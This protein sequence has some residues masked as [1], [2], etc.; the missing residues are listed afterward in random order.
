[1]V[2]R[3]NSYLYSFR[4]FDRGF[5]WEDADLVTGSGTCLSPFLYSASDGTV[6]LAWCSNADGTYELYHTRSSDNGRTWEQPYRKIETPEDYSQSVSVVE[7]DPGTIQIYFDNSARVVSTDNGDNFDPIENFSSDD[8]FNSR[9]FKDSGGRLWLI[10]WS[11]SKVKCRYSDN[12][13]DSWSGTQEIGEA[14]GGPDDNPIMFEAQ[15]GTL[16][17][18]WHDMNLQEDLFYATSADNGAAWTSRKLITCSP[19]S[20]R[21]SSPSIY[22]VDNI[23]YIIYGNDDSGNFDLYLAAWPDF[24]GDG[25]LA[26]IDNCPGVYNPGQENDDGDDFGNACDNCS[27]VYNPSQEDLDSD[28]VGDS[29]DAL[30]IDFTGSPRNGTVPLEVSFS[31][32]SYTIDVITDWF[33]DFG[34]EQTSDLQNPVHTYTDSGSYDVTL[35]I[36]NGPEYDTLV[37]PDYIATGPP[38]NVDFSIDVTSGPINLV[39]NFTPSSDVALDSAFWEYGDGE[40]G[41]DTFHTYTTIDTFD[42]RYIFFIGNYEDTVLKE[43]AIITTPP[44]IN[45]MAN[46]EYGL[47][48]IR[49]GLIPALPSGW[50][51]V[52]THG[53]FKYMNIQHPDIMMF[54]WNI[55]MEHIATRWSNPA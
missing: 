25:V 37:R 45:I 1:M 16:W 44:Y 4:S 15:D 14:S 49:P 26:E 5:T 39:V 36:S 23:V 17:A 29:C 8:I 32:Q 11:G 38:P 43:D 47:S 28:G 13:G 3:Y 35:I 48:P 55:I 19:A 7:T 10:G 31:D 9:V 6:W 53:L 24:D 50:N 20:D 34:D 27:M 30:S 41:I 42:V 51:S 2:Y 52:T 46:V 40:T 18:V 33:W 21:I 54:H 22:E 12:N